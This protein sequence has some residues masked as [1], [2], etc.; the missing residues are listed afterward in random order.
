MKLDNL[1][2]FDPGLAFHDELNP[3]L[4]QGQDMLPAVESALMKIANVFIETLGVDK[5][6][7]TDIILT[8]S[9]ANYNWSKLSDIDL[10]F[11]LDMDNLGCEDCQVDVAGCLQAK[12]S[13]WNLQHDTTIH[14]FPVEVYTHANTED[15]VGSAAAY[16][17]MHR[18]WIS[19][20]AQGLKGSQV[21]YPQSQVQAKAEA[22][23]YEID[24]AV[25]TH[26]DDRD[27]L[28][29]LADRLWRMRGQG[30]KSAGELSLENLVFKALRNNGYV[31][32]IRAAVAHAEDNSL[33]L[34]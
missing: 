14:G 19:M 24:Q 29:D 30:L 6:A 20:P 10:H 16:S 27:A 3:A 4:W 23:A 18:K 15:L 11:A 5:A 32:K 33:S 31:Q 34:K 17:L 2:E 8:G 9:N 26:A 28:Q 12:K 22:F 21:V 13:L 7:V 1:L 25:E